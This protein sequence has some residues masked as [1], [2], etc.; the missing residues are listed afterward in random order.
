M[1]K[2]RGGQKLAEVRKG[3][4]TE[5][6]ALMAYFLPDERRDSDLLRMLNEQRVSMLTVQE[7]I[8]YV[9]NVFSAMATASDR[10]M[11]SY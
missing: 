8:G 5:A 2:L 7:G 3:V 11:L 1:R 4:N 9:F 6:F 10:H